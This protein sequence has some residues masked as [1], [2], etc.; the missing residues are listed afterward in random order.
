MHELVHMFLS[1]QNKLNKILN[2]VERKLLKGTHLAMTIKEMWRGSLPI[3]RLFKH[4]YLAQTKFCTFKGA[5]RQGETQV[6]KYLM[7]D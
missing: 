6:E 4:L 3:A 2:V 7:L 5:V 1:K